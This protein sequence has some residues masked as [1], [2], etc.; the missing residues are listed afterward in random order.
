MTASPAR[1][2]SCRK[3]LPRTLLFAQQPAASSRSGSCGADVGS[4]GVHDVVLRLRSLPRSAFCARRSNLRCLLARDEVP[5]PVRPTNSRQQTAPASTPEADAAGPDAEFWIRRPQR[6]ASLRARRGRGE[7]GETARGGAD[8][9]EQAGGTVE[10]SAQ[11]QLDSLD[12]EHASS[13]VSLLSQTDTLASSYAPQ[14]SSSDITTLSRCSSSP[15]TRSP[16]REVPPLP[17]PIPI[18]SRPAL[19]RRHSSVDS[20]TVPSSLA[21]PMSNAPAAPASLPSSSRQRSFLAAVSAAPF[22]NLVPVSDSASNSRTIDS[23]TTARLPPRRVT[24]LTVGEGQ[25]ARVLRRKAS[26]TVRGRYGGAGGGTDASMALP[27]RRS[28]SRDRPRPSLSADRRAELPPSPAYPSRPSRAGTSLNT[29]TPLAPPLPT[30]ASVMASMSSESASS[31][32]KTSTSSRPHLSRPGS[33][34]SAL[35][36][37]SSPSDSD[38]NK[39][40]FRSGMLKLKKST[41]NTLI[42]VDVL[43]RRGEPRYAAPADREAA[44]TPRRFPRL[45]TTTYFAYDAATQPHTTS[46]EPAA[47]R[48]RLA[49]SLDAALLPDTPSSGEYEPDW[50][51]SPRLAGCSTTFAAAITTSSTDAVRTGGRRRNLLRRRR[52]SR[53]SLVV[54]PSCPTSRPHSPSARQTP[55]FTSFAFGL[56]APFSSQSCS[57]GRACQVSWPSQTVHPT[58]RRLALSLS[59]S[60]GASS[61]PPGGVS[62]TACPD[63][64]E[65]DPTGHAGTDAPLVS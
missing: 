13:S 2:A 49:R 42:V 35:T 10:R 32:A 65:E 57:P 7:G 45:S 50:P 44:S 22:S 51:S 27:S 39:S 38:S 14:T 37:S 6:K 18:A 41:A 26:V 34:R 48:Q 8:R 12:A 58:L 36:D 4:T 61:A 43:L 56:A 62:S 1:L 25:P 53:L 5:P 40:A 52:T 31:A 20:S 17:Q 54:R 60:P 29:T 30:L 19:H 28:V 9:S 21:L 59:M 46:H 33:S 11:G 47:H 55:A 24:T 63:N 3:L 15:S 16:G 64:G 23:Y